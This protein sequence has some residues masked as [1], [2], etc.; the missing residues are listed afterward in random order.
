MTAWTDLVKKVFNENKHKSGY[1]FSNALLDAS[2]LYKNGPGSKSRKVI[3]RVATTVAEN[4]GDYADSK[5]GFK[6]SKKT[7]RRRRTRSRR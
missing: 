1:K 4:V 2:K 3:S 6:S 5:M 7:A